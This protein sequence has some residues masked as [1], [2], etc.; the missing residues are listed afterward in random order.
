MRI[1]KS[2]KFGRELHFNVYT[3]KGGERVEIRN[4][5]EWDRIEYYIPLNEE[6]IDEVIKSYENLIRKLKESRRHMKEVQK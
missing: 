5:S 6:N 2:E 1:V 3:R 4:P